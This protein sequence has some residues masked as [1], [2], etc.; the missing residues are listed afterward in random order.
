MLE[1]CTGHAHVDLTAITL[2]QK[3]HDLAHVAQGL[4]TGLLDQFG[5]D[6]VHLLVIKLRRHEFLDDVNFG[7]FLVG[8][9]LPAALGIECRR[10]LA[11]LDHLRKNVEHLFIIG[12]VLALAAQRD[13]AV[14]DCGMDEPQR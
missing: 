14:D 10:L 7:Q 11:L 13:I 12:P 5:N 2:L 8:K 9:V 6:T 1:L 4:R 3:P